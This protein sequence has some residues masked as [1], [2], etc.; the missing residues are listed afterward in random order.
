MESTAENISIE[1]EV[2]YFNDNSNQHGIEES[3]IEKETFG[4]KYDNKKSQVT[5]KK[6]KKKTINYLR[7][8]LRKM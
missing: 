6:K 8:N 5:V 1:C 4:E 2:Q 3:E 7:L